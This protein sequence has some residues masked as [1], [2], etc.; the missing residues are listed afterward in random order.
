MLP[1]PLAHH[2]VAS[3]ID[4]IILPLWRVSFQF[5]HGGDVAACLLKGGK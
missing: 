2:R 3:P 5:P 1:S 4:A